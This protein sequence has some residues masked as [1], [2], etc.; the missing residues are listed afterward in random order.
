VVPLLRTGRTST[1]P[2]SVLHH[3]LNAS[4]Q[5]R[6]IP[7]SELPPDSR[8][9]IALAYTSLVLTP[10]TYIEWLASRLRARGVTFVR[11]TADSLAQVQAGTFGPA[12]D[13]IVN[14]TGVGART[15]GGVEDPDV[16]AIRYVRPANGDA[17]CGAHARTQWPDDAHRGSG[18][19][20]GQDGAP[21][22]DGLLL[23]HPAPRRHRRP[24]RDQG[25]QR[26]VRRAARPPRS[27]ALTLAPPVASQ[28]RNRS[29]ART[30]ASARTSSTRASRRPRTR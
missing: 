3:P 13:V 15:L 12:P 11:G 25:A 14:A 10:P 17:A 2:L 1:S 7:P 27:I 29:S 30:S 26:P 23:H 28:T 5:Y 6:V 24:R 22:R 20:A 18:A 8:A 16:E 21:Q 4:T 9:R 19:Q